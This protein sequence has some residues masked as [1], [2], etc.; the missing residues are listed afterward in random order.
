MELSNSHLHLKMDL[1]I[2]L[3]H[4]RTALM[5]LSSF[6]HLLKMEPIA[7]DHLKTA[8]MVLS[9]SHLHL[10]MDLE[11]VLD[12]LRTILM[13]PCHLLLLR[14]D[15]I[16]HNQELLNNKEESSKVERAAVLTRS[17]H[18]VLINLHL[19]MKRSLP[20]RMMTRK[21]HPRRRKTPKKMKKMIKK[22]H[23]E[24]KMAM[25]K[26]KKKKTSHPERKMAKK[27]KMMKKDHPKRKMTK[28]KM[29]KKDHPKRM[30]KKIMK[31]VNIDLLKE[32]KTK[33]E[34]MRE[35]INPPREINTKKIKMAKKIKKKM[36]TEHH[37]RTRMNEQ[38]LFI[39]EITGMKPNLCR[40]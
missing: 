13:V 35:K 2:V 20:R 17:Q 36:I 28:K 39:R 14:M 23:P 22:D 30:M 15:P 7:Q 34:K 3:D 32:I 24:R 21:S 25:R 31:K 16:P 4:P 27:K 9:N 40:L 19:K 10:K 12:H 8:L 6:H 5:E 37:P 11:I 33:K 1:E 18:R 26:K 38:Q 29:M